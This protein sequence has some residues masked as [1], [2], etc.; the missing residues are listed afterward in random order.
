MPK[1]SSVKVLSK[2]RAYKLSIGGNEIVALKLE[3]YKASQLGGVL[4][5]IGV[6]M[7]G[8]KAEMD[9][10]LVVVKDERGIVQPMDV[11]AEKVSREIANVS[12]STVGTVS[13][14]ISSRE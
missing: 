14:T 3:G 7:E 6:G 8:N 10:W 5:T 9:D 1:E 4:T 12:G 2:N 13:V 11:W